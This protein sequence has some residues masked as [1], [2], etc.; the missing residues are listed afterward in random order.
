MARITART[1]RQSASARWWRPSHARL[2]RRIAPARLCRPRASA[3]A[4]RTSAHLTG[5]SARLWNA[6][7][8][9]R[10]RASKSARQASTCCAS[11][12]TG[13]ERRMDLGPGSRPHRAQRLRAQAVDLPRAS[14]Y[15]AEGE[16]EHTRAQCAGGVDGD[17][18]DDLGVSSQAGGLG[19]EHE[20]VLASEQ[21]G[22]VPGAKAPGAAASQPAKARERERDQ[23]GAED[24]V[25]PHGLSACSTRWH[26]LK[27]PVHSRSAARSPARSDRDPERRDG[28][29]RCAAP[30]ARSPSTPPAR[31]SFTGT[32]LR[33]VRR[34]LRAP[35]APPCR[36]REGLVD[37]LGLA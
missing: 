16:G 36:L 1:A 25:Q 6:A 13:D 32:G 35:P 7:V 33:V 28:S 14:R 31:L 3:Y 9:S 30:S 21:C 19:I 17:H 22:E 34:P 26:G 10:I 4:G 29:T 24:G 8:C 27:S 5:G 15:R 2:S 12:S 23:S 37:R 18:L 20:H 11:R